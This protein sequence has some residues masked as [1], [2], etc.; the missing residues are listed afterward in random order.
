LDIDALV[1]VVVRRFK[2]KEKVVHPPRDHKDGRVECYLGSLVH[3]INVYER[4]AHACSYCYVEWK[5]SPPTIVAHENLLERVLRDLKKFYIGRKVVLNLGS[6]TD[7]YQPIE[8]KLKHTRKLVKLL[9][10]CNLTF[11]LCTKSNLIL[12]D[13]DL[14]KGYENVWIGVSLTS[15]DEEFS[16]VFEP[17]T[18]N[19]KA[20]LNLVKRLIDAG[21]PVVVRV[22][23]IIP[24]V[25]DKPD[26]LEETISEL[27]K[28]GV[29]KVTADIL[30][31]DRSKIMFYGWENMPKWKTPLK[32]SLKT[33]SN[34][35]G[36]NNLEDKLEKLYYRDGETLY[37]YVVPPISY[38]F[39]VLSL[40]KNACDKY[41][42]KFS[43]CRM[44]VDIKYK[45]NSW[46]E[47]GKFRCACYM[48]NPV[49]VRFKK[50]REAEESLKKIKIED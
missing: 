21:I 18:P 48:K 26:W 27:A 3:V 44:G 10:E 24:M 11:Y 50:I 37:G 5:H 28:I 4:C 33:W 16:R 19:P 34:I 17:N 20:R 39:K 43:T 35:T 14:Y 42:L 36:K 38:R 49:K 30:K 9:K 12:R 45:L 15:L 25:N 29:E 6:A 31:L 8:E 32:N 41:G 7:P 23:P 13:L 47:N 2:R 40:V 46:I 22:S 1:E